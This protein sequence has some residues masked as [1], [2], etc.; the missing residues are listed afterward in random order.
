[1]IAPVGFA[2]LCRDGDE[3][4][5][6]LPRGERPESRGETTEIRSGSFDSS[7]GLDKRDEISVEPPVAEDVS[8]VLAA[9]DGS[10]PSLLKI[11]NI[12][13][14]SDFSSSVCVPVAMFSSDISISY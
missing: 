1:M 8:G 7:S 5:V 11:S 6:A 2:W 4:A 10:P 3:G 9:V 13:E 12:P 14:K